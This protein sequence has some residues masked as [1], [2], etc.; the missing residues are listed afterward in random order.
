M[1]CL[2]VSQ[3]FERHQEGHVADRLGWVG[4]R[5]HI[6]ASIRECLQPSQNLQGSWCQ[7]DLVRLWHL[8]L[9]LA[10]GR[11][12]PDLLIPVHLTPLAKRNLGCSEPSEHNEFEAELGRLRAG[13]RSQLEHVVVDRDVWNGRIAFV[14]EC[15][16]GP[17][18]TNGALSFRISRTCARAR[19]VPRRSNC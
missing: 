4:A 7:W 13:T 15:R 11:Y 17:Q 9:L 19:E 3:P 2:G 8:L 16:A 1:Y 14:R 10:F 6:P 5:K 12:R 18:S